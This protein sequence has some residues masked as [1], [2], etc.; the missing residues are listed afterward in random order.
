M[1]AMVGDGKVFWGLRVLPFANAVE[2]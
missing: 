1:V 2:R